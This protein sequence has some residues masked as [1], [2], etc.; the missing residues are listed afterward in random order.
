M[1]FVCSRIQLSGT[2]LFSISDIFMASD[3]CLLVNIKH[4][5]SEAWHLACLWIWYQKSSPVHVM[6]RE[7]K[8][9]TAF[10]M[11]FIWVSYII[12][13]EMLNFTQSTACQYQANSGRRGFQPIF[14][15]DTKC[16][17]ACGSCQLIADWHIHQK[18]FL[19]SSPAMAISPVTQQHQCHWCNI[20][21][22]NYRTRFFTH[23]WTTINPCQAGSDTD[24]PSLWNVFPV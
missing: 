19:A 23:R 22:A 1:S 24:K 13:N 18:I 14:W 17:V 6:L 16:H 9:Q 12:T 21:V 20:R 15:P 3:K 10:P 7:Q 5:Q 11:S 4:L 8:Q 2:T